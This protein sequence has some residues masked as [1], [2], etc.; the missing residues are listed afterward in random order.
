MDTI[1]NAI[2]GVSAWINTVF[3]PLLRPVF[4]PIDDLLTP[5]PQPFWKASAVGLFLAAMVWIFCLRKEY[6]NV[7]APGKEWWYDLR[8][9][10]V[11]SMLPHVLIYLWL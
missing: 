10:T 3:G 4:L 11:L 6:V 9:W 5:I 7:D 2:I 8:L 1:S